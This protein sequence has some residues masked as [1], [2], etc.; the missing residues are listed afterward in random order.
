[1]DT[2]AFE[3]NRLYALFLTRNPDYSGTVSVTGHSLGDES[4]ISHPNKVIALS[5]NSCCFFFV[6]AGS[7]IL[8][9]LL[10]NQNNGSA[11]PIIPTANGQEAQVRLKIIS[12]D[13]NVQRVAFWFHIP[14]SKPI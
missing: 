11:M 6:L 14:L 3:I 4:S 1:M 8:F 9:D 13:L 10:S 12:F 7:L 2:V 5:V